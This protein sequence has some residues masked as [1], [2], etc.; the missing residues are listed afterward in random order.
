MNGKRIVHPVHSAMMFAMPLLLGLVPSAMAEVT[1]IRQPVSFTLSGCTALPVGVIV[2]GS[3]DAFIVTTTRVD[4][5]G[6]THLQVNNVTTGTATDSNGAAYIFN[7]HNHVSQEVPPGGFP[8][9]I[10]IGADHFNL[11]G[12]GQANKVQVHFVARATFFSPTAFVIDFINVH[13]NPFSCD[14]I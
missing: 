1:Q 13:G 9:Q 8:S 2:H 12:A 14:P 3:G 7:Y 10:T 4:K 11:V 6:V 5:N